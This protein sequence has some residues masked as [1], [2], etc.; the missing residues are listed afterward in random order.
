MTGLTL[1]D[2]AADIASVIEHEGR[3]PVVVVG[4]AYG[5]FVV[6]RTLLHDPWNLAAHWVWLPLYHY[7]LG[8]LRTG[9]AWRDIDATVEAI[10]LLEPLRVAW[11][12][13]S[14]SALTEPTSVRLS[15]VG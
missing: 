13:A 11:H 5:H 9:N 4:H 3:G 7:V 1:H 6:A 15:A 8:I 14:E 2:Y 10:E 12:S